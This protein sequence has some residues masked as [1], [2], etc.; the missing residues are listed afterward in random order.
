MQLFH[1]LKNTRGAIK[2]LNALLISGAAGAVFAYTVGTVSDNQIEAERRVRTLSGISAAA[3]QQGLLRRDGKLTSINVGDGLNQLATAEERAAMQGNNALDKYVANQRALEG[4]DA[5]L[6]R[7]AQFSETDGLNT[8]NR[9]ISQISGQYV[10]GTSVDTG[11]GVSGAVTRAGETPAG[12]DKPGASDRPSLAPAAITR[13]SGSPSGSSAGAVSGGIVGGPG[14]G[15]NNPQEGVRMSGA[16]PGGSNIISQRGLDK[17]PL[18]NSGTSFAPGYRD[19]RVRLAKNSGRMQ[20]ELKQISKFSADALRRNENPANVVGQAYMNATRSGGVDVEQPI[21]EDD[22]TSSEDLKNPSGHK[23]NAIGNHLGNEQNKLEAR[24]KAQAKLTRRLL[25]TLALS[26][27]MMATGMIVLPK[28]HGIWRVAAAAVMVGIVFAASA[29]L[30]N[31]ANHF[32][33]DYGKGGG[34]GMAWLA[35]ILS[36]FLV[37]GM[38]C[39]AV[40]PKGSWNAVKKLWGNIVGGFKKMFNPINI[41]LGSISN[42]IKNTLFGSLFK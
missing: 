33:R 11:E 15:V 41:A 31:A 7:A 18:G 5:A 42:T 3:P 32:I 23:L 10:P 9:D 6:G 1:F 2:P 13:A 14:A 20:D 39:V 36:P 25:L 37:A 24:E 26:L 40:D 17:G 29:V 21:T 4:M 27:G 35:K 12:D 19:G 34:L 8:A 30:F 28:L 22:T 16:M 38:T